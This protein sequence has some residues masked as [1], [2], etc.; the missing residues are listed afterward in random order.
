[1]LRSLILT[2]IKNDNVVPSSTIW[3]SNP[4]SH[5]IQTP[6]VINM[7]NY[8]MKRDLITRPVLGPANPSQVEERVTNKLAIEWDSVRRARIQLPH[9]GYVDE[10]SK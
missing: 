4:T 3:L 9:R 1:M 6:A 2:S 10:M 8:S 7:Q 5:L